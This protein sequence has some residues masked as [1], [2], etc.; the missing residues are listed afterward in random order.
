MTIVGALLTAFASSTY[1]VTR[2]QLKQDIAA[3]LADEHA[4]EHPVGTEPLQ[5][6]LTRAGI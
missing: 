6:K 1:V 3:H 2:T 5:T 4:T